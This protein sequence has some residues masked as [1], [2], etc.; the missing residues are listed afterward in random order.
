MTDSCPII[1]I[2]DVDNIFVNDIQA[3]FQGL[4]SEVLAEYKAIPISYVYRGNL[5][6]SCWGD[7][8]DSRLCPTLKNGMR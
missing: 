7:K 4:I 3:V 5:W 1:E 6:E 2:P 8:Y